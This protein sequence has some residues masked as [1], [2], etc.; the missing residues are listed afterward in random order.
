MQTVTVIGPNLPRP[1]SDTGTMHVHAAGC[2]DIKRT[3]GR[4]RLEAPPWSIDAETVAQ[5]IEDIYPAEDFCYD[6]ADPAEYSAY[7][8]DVHVFPCVTLPEHKD[9]R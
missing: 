6:P 5:I 7:R 2:A 9:D 8:G 4:H 3:Y 1:L